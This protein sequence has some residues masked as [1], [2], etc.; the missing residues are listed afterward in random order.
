MSFQN[1]NITE[2]TNLPEKQQD[3][4]GL[5][6][7]DCPNYSADTVTIVV[8]GKPDARND[9]ETLPEIKYHRYQYFGK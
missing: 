2:V 9:F 4:F 7:D 3:S 8:E 6:T 1:D 5:S